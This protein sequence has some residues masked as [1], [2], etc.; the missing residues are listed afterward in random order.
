MEQTEKVLSL[1]VSIRKQINKIRLSLRRS[2]ILHNLPS[3]PTKYMRIH[4]ECGRWM[5]GPRNH[6]QRLPNEANFTSGEQF[7]SPSVALS[8]NLRSEQRHKPS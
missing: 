6:L 8:E 4:Y 2:L 1:L 7:V 3:V 5:D